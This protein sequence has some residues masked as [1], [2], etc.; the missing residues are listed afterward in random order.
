MDTTPHPLSLPF[1]GILER[2][3]LE[4]SGVA[5]LDQV[6]SPLGGGE[7]SGGGEP[8]PTSVLLGGE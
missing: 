8:A 7:P 1:D 6:Y 5:P 2:L 3:G 4:D